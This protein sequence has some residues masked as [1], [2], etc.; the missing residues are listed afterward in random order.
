M[1]SA[2]TNLTII[3]N[4]VEDANRA[5]AI[6]KDVVAERT[7]D[8]PKELDKFIA[9]IV[10]DGNTVKIEESYSL[11]SNTFCELI[12]QIIRRITKY[13]FGA[14]TAEAWYTSFNSDYEAEFSA[15]VL[16]NGK[17]KIS[18]SEHES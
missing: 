8:Y 17:L 4:S 3:T 9:D 12:P 2:T 14:F 15:R 7:P 6:I 5:V 13:D 18:F 11:M 16:K 1:G 10:V